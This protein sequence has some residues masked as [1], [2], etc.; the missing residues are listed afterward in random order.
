MAITH[1]TPADRTFS[2]PGKIAWEEAHIGGVAATTCEQLGASSSATAAT[3]TA[4][5]QSAL[6]VG[7]RVTIET[8]GTYLLATQ[9]SNPYKSGH[10]YCLDLTQNNTEFVIGAG[11]VLKLADGQ[12]TDAGGAVDILV[13]SARTN[14]TVRGTNGGK[15]RITG[16]TAGQTGWSGGY[17]QA[18]TNGG[19]V[20]GYGVNDNI[21]LEDLQLDDHWSNPCDISN[22]SSRSTN[23]FYRRLYGFNCGEGFEMQRVD[24]LIIDDCVYE[25]LSGVMVG[26]G[27]EIANCTN[28]LIDKTRVRNT[29][30]AG[31]SFDLF[32]SKHGVLSNF[33]IEGTDGGVS[34]GTSS[35]VTSDDILVTDG[36][37]NVN[38]DAVVLEF[39]EGG[40]TY[41][42]IRITLA[43]SS[44][45]CAQIVG[46]SSMPRLVLN[47][48]YIKGA[49]GAGISV[50]GSRKVTIN[51]PTILDSVSS[52]DGIKIART[53]TAAQDFCI[54]GGKIT[55]CRWGIS[56]D[57]Q[58]DAS[59]FPVGSINGVD[60]IGNSSGTIQPAGANHKNIEVAG[61]ELED[62]GTLANVAF[63]R[64]LLD[65]G[66]TVSTLGLGYKNQTL[67][68]VWEAGGSSRT[69]NDKS[70]SGN[71]NLANSESI[72]TETGDSLTLIYRP[73][74]GEWFEVCRSLN[75]AGSRSMLVDGWFQDNMAA[76][77]SSVALTRGAGAITNRFYCPNAGYLT[78]LGLALSANR[79][80]G[81]LTL[82]YWVNGGGP[83]RAIF[84]STNIAYAV[85]TYPRLHTSINAAD[86][87]ELKI[88]TD[89][90]WAP[91]T[92]D[93]HAFVMI[94]Q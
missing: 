92:D 57:A 74:V 45:E 31:A 80:A 23:V 1:R 94:Q 47:N 82:E 16:N 20:V 58:A 65:P 69:V 40:A 29:S 17:S 3:N 83:N 36:V 64:R 63:K 78:K 51:N 73:A 9:G 72:V 38:G 76:S 5:I 22:T 15:G 88:T 8:P 62:T 44:A 49:A 30:A 75:G 55:G 60:L 27:V 34:A 84:V 25:D 89:G 56:I 28:F 50:Y 61:C 46:D 13:Y 81:T 85:S 93:I 79:S 12:Q 32:G 53:T 6:N 52:G 70:V 7:G 37:I 91:T 24:G 66:V 4:A 35:G 42:N 26:D 21:T 43:S 2:P 19:I 48:I 11:V 14:I 10:K 18:T 67:E 39:P 59:W 68:I 90:S 71:I 86:Y 54:N 33:I 87:I 41:Q 77:Q